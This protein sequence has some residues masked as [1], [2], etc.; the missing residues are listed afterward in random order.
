MD[1][2]DIVKYMPT[3]TVGKIVDVKEADGRAWFKLDRTGLFYVADTLS[4]ADA[5]EYKTVSFKDKESKKTF[6]GASTL[7]DLHEMERDVDIS[8]MTPSGGG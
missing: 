2:G 6:K 8:D 3:N 5:S 1:K 4:P 7:E